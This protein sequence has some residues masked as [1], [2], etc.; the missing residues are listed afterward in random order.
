MYVSVCVWQPETLSITF[1]LDTIRPCLLSK[2]KRDE[3]KVNLD[4]SVPQLQY[5]VAK[6]SFTQRII[7]SNYNSI[8]GLVFKVSIP[9][10]PLYSL[11]SFW[12]YRGL[13]LRC[14]D[15][16]V[17]QLITRLLNYP[18]FVNYQMEI[19]RTLLIPAAAVF[20]N[21]TIENFKNPN[22]L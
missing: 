2:Q 3:R 6:G 12:L 1:L 22:P 16:V 20:T 7:A 4:F 13:V 21:F 15:Y 14:L 11:Q 10:K 18:L 5:Y 17:F 19:A 8:S 9:E